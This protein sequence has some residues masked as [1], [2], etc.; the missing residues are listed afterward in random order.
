MDITIERTKDSNELAKLNE[1]VQTWHHQNFPD[2]FKPY[3]PVAIAKAFKHLLGDPENIAL[4][5]TSNGE[6]VGYLLGN[7]KRRPESAFQFKKEALHID[8]MVV[9]PSHRGAGVGKRLLEAATAHAREHNISEIQLDYWAGNKLAETFF[10][11]N[12]FVH[13]NHRMSI[14]L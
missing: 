4:I 7:I 1:Q 9:L 12:G 6:S 5:A 13:F 10:S 2:E 3:D 8:Q 11:G 14:Q